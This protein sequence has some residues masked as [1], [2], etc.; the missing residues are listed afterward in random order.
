MARSIESELTEAEII[1]LV[2]EYDS[3]ADVMNALELLQQKAKEYHDVVYD[4]L[5]RA[6]DRS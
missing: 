5:Y 6:K 1:Y 2:K 4:N 3:T